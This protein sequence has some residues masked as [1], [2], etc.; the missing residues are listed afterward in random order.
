MDY[1]YN[2]NLVLVVGERSK[3]KWREDLSDIKVNFIRY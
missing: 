2:E 3:L 1:L